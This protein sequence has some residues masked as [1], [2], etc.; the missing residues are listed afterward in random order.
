MILTI[1]FTIS[2]AIYDTGKRFKNHIPRAIFRLIFIIL[3]SRFEIEN[4]LGNLATFY[5][6]FDYALNFLEGRKI[7]YIGNT[8][9]SDQFWRLLGWELQLIFKIILFIILN[10]LI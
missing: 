3:I 5:L 4:T 2:S 6:I 1:I 10:F 7:N 8:A 9:I